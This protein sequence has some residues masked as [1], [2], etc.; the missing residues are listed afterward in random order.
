SGRAV[1]HLDV[2]GVA[3]RGFHAEQERVEARPLARVDR[4]SHRARVALRSEDD[5]RARQMREID[6]PVDDADGRDPARPRLVRGLRR[7]REAAATHGDAR[8]GRP[9]LGSRTA[10]ATARDTGWHATA[11]AQRAI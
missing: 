6:R 2:E 4:R 5:L 7:D 10:T 9:A 8:S 1:A 3:F 11:A